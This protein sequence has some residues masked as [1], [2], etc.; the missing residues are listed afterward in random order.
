MTVLTRRYIKSGQ[1]Y[2]VNITLN[3][4]THCVFLNVFFS[5]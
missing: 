5:F 2:I 4:L 1:I 3:E